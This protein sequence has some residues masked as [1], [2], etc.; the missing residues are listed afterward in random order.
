[1]RSVNTSLDVLVSKLRIDDDIRSDVK[2][3]V[4]HA[5]VCVS[6]YSNTLETEGVAVL[7]Q[8]QSLAEADRV[9]QVNVNKMDLT[10]NAFMT[11]I[12][13][14]RHDVISMEGGV[15]SN[16]ESTRKRR[17]EHEQEVSR[18]K[19]KLTNLKD[20][21]KRLEQKISICEKDGEKYN[22][23]ANELDK[24]A[25]EIDRKAEEQEKMGIFGL[26][27]SGVGIVLAPVTGKLLFWYEKAQQWI[28]RS[29]L[30]FGIIDVR[31]FKCLRSL[32][33]TAP[34]NS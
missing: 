25:R 21:I 12:T 23:A 31:L 18:K 26:V 9:D 5:V 34:V 16:I 7:A 1:M 10:L 30:I 33:N 24:H 32:V 22:K 20:K 13:A 11:R 15:H 8:K 19:E 14:I 6:D 17:K 29:V 28:I 4:N 27:A 3:V 2:Q